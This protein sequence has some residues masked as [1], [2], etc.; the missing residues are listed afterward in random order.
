MVQRIIK[1]L[2]D[3]AL[4]F[5]PATYKL[6]ICLE[7]N[8]VALLLHTH[9]GKFYG[10]EYYS[11][12]ES[13]NM[14]FAKTFDLLL[15]KSRLFKY[16]NLTTAIYYR[17]ENMMLVPAQFETDT[18]QLLDVQFGFKQGETTF[19]KN[20]TSD[21]LVAWKIHIVWQNAMQKQFPH[22]TFHPS[23]GNLFAGIKINESPTIYLA[24]GNGLVE[25]IVLK[26]K[27]LQLAKCFLYQ[28][29]EDLT[30]NLMN[31][32]KQLQIEPSEVQMKVQGMVEIDS[33]LYTSL[34]LNFM[35]VQPQ[36]TD[37]IHWPAALKSLPTHY[38]TGLIQAV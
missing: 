32:C 3:E 9:K 26:Q 8:A 19:Q 22:H 35:D 28:N 1:N 33:L 11:W 6:K 23:I 24:F 31:I 5:D 29:V 16:K 15:K 20:I 14:D 18:K 36:I 38:F 4:V 25:I 17:T 13:D 30:Y 2:P 7:P 37:N 21:I 10:V 34:Q 12:A 27:K